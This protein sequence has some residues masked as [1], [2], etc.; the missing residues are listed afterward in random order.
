MGAL[1]SLNDCWSDDD[2]KGAE[3]RCRAR[4][5]RLDADH[6]GNARSATADSADDLVADAL[7]PREGPAETDLRQQSEQEARMGDDRGRAGGRSARTLPQLTT[8]A[9]RQV[10]LEAS[11]G[12]GRRARCQMAPHL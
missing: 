4:A 6:P 12:V 7:Q 11:N 10:C 9:A 8:D 2:A 5:R 1:R 3:P